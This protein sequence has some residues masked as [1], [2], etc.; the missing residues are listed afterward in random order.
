VPGLGRSGQELAQRLA[1]PATGAVAHHG[2]ADLARHRDADADLGC[3]GSLVEA[4]PADRLEE[5][6]PAALLG[7]ARGGHELAAPA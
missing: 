5:E 4:A 2:A 6:G 1:Q 3:R 7:A